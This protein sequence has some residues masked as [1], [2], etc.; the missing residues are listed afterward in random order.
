VVQSELLSHLG[1]RV[2]VPL[3]ASGQFEPIARLHP[4]FEIDGTVVH[5]YPTE[6]AV[7]PETLLRK[8]VANLRAA[9]DAM[10]AALDLVFTGV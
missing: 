3:A 6:I 9:R 1:T 10:V 5:F 8:R 4:A 2:V 7:L